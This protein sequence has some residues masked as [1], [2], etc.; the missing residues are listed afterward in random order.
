MSRPWLLE[1]GVSSPADFERLRG[2]LVGKLTEDWFRLTARPIDRENNHQSRAETLPIWKA[3]QLAFQDLYGKPNGPL[4]PIQ[5]DKISPLRL[6]KQAC[7]CLV[8]AILQK[9]GKVLTHDDFL[10][11]CV[12]ALQEL[13]PLDEDKARFMMDIERRKTEF[14]A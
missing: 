8:N 6:V 11:R 12:L 3:I 2:S 10:W 1:N 9:G 14:Q 13:V 4:V 7:G 5:R